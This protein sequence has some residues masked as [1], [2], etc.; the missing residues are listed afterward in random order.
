MSQEKQKVKGKTIE[1]RIEK[2][3]ILFP[4]PEITKDTILKADELIRTGLGKRGKETDQMFLMRVR[5]CVVCGIDLCLINT[6]YNVGGKVSRYVELKGIL[7][8][9]KYPHSVVQTVMSTP[10]KCIVKGSCDGKDNWVKVEYDLVKAEKLNEN[11]GKNKHWKY[12]QQKMLVKSAKGDLF[13][14]LSD[15]PMSENLV[16]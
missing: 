9:Q 2:F 12:N 7:F 1:E 10:E 15:T 11:Y 14:I 6:T 4:S 13:D 16:E 8:G 5:Y 3:E